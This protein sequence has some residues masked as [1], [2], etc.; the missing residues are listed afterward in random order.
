MGSGGKQPDG[1]EPSLLLAPFD[2]SEALAARKAWAQYQGLG[3]D[4]KNSIGMQLVLIPPGEYLMGSGETLEQLRRDFKFG[5]KT[6]LA[7]E[8]PQHRVR[9]ARPYYLGAYEVTKGQ[10]R[11]FADA[12]H[13]KSEAEKDGLGGAGFDPQKELQPDG[14]ALHQSPRF[15]WR[16]WGVEDGENFPVVNMTWNDATAFCDWLSLRDGKK[17]RLPTEAEWEYACR[18][19]TTGRFYN[20]NDTEAL[21]RIGNVA[22]LSLA[23]KLHY[24]TLQSS[25]GWAFTSPVGQFKPNN[26]GLYDMIGNA[27]EWCRD[28]YEPNWYDQS[29]IVNPAGPSEPAESP[30]HAFRG[31]GW[32]ADA[33]YCRCAARYLAKPTLR[34][35]SAGFRVLCE[36]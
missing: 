25:D 5:N 35:G 24:K 2:Q 4:R 30:L 33:V 23:Q 18:A 17:Y 10:F 6:W 31:G 9:I 28:F 22:D 19:G 1:Q 3:E 13:Y 32:E 29:P 8:L 14:K 20:G 12:T 21:T 7:S 11:T 36:P 26:F 34:D 16:N 15:N 27:F